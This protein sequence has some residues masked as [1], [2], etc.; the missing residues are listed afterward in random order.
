MRKKYLI[1]GGAGFI[2]CN[3]AHYHL[4]Q[5]DE[6]VVH[7]DEEGIGNLRDF[8]GDVFVLYGDTPLLRGRT[9]EQLAA[10]KTTTGAELVI[11]TGSWP[12]PGRSSGSAGWSMIRIRCSAS[13]TANGTRS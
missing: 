10:H 12:L 13:S 1:T 9:L 5:G 7:E 2:G 3:L 11:L 4:E 8:V 6:V